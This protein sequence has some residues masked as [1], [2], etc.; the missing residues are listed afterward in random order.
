M[1]VFGSA[2]A[3]GLGKV[4]ADDADNADFPNP[5]V[6]SEKSVVLKYRELFMLFELTVQMKGLEW[7]LK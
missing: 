4:T 6:P 3:R 1:L 5:S 2:S 7:G